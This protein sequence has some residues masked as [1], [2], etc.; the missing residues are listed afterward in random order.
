VRVILDQNLP[1][2]AARLLRAT[3]RDVTNTRE[4]GMARASDD[5]IIGY[6]I[7]SRSVVVTLDR[8]FHQHLATRGMLQPSVIRIREHPLD[9]FRVRDIVLDV[10]S[11][12][13]GEL[14]AGA[15]ITV[16]RAV[17][18]VRLLPIRPVAS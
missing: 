16:Q 10:L 5:A 4:L 11:R 3:G 15:A 8:D 9:E 2:D 6:A 18:R 12:F 1:H 7:E 14:A 13:E 17:V